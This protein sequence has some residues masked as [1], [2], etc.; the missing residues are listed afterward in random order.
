MYN[1]EQMLDNDFNELSDDELIVLLA[2]SDH[3]MMKTRLQKISLIYNEVFRDKHKE[4]THNAYFFGGYSDSIDESATN[5]TDIGIL[6][7][8][9]N[10]YTLTEYGEKL[11]K[12][13]I[14]NWDNPATEDVPKV[15]KSMSGLSDKS[16]VGLTYYFYKDTT[17]N[18]TIK[19]SVD[20]IN[21]KAHFDGKKLTE[22]PLDYF[23]NKV[24]MGQIFTEK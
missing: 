14:D 5:L 18:S 17:K 23:E 2:M 7:Y 4:S 13:V 9:Q 20:R 24:R 6:K 10:G 8:S 11:K 1:E 19:P 12:Y 3:P 22:M 21:E 16:V 15:V